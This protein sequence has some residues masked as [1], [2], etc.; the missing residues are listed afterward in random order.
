MRKVLYAVFLLLLLAAGSAVAVFAAGGGVFTFTF[1][2]DSR[3]ATVPSRTHTVTVSGRRRTVTDP[4]RTYTFPGQTHSVTTTVPD[5]TASTEST[6]STTSNEPAPIAGQGYSKVFADEF[7]GT[8]LDANV[9][10]QKEFWEDEP[11]AGAVVVSNG[12]VKI[13]NA[14]P[15]YD[16]QSIST[17][18][19][20][21]LGA[22]EALVAVRLLRG[23]HEV[24][25]RQ[26]LVAG[27]L[28]PLS[29]AGGV[30]QLAE[31]Y[32]P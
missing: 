25:G 12:T 21:G 31:L 28:A 18:P 24:H 23:S 27:L 9:W 17:G 5:M 32:G 10:N 20:W 30:A 3:T 6:T 22:G 16:D 13:N 1:T 8:A 2:D 19:Y 11:R 4:A 26:G 29:G 15:Y 7:D 14:R